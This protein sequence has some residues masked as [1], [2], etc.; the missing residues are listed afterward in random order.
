VLGSCPGRHLRRQAE[1]LRLPAEVPTRPTSSR[2]VQHEI[3][4]ELPTFQWPGPTESSD[5]W[6]GGLI[7]RHGDEASSESNTFLED[8]DVD[9]KT[10]CPASRQGRDD[11]TPR[12]F[13]LVFRDRG[14]DRISLDLP[15]VRLAPMGEARVE[16]HRK[17]RRS[18]AII[19]GGISG[20]RKRRSLPRSRK[21]SSA[22]SSLRCMEVRS[23]PWPRRKTGLYFTPSQARVTC[24]RP[25]AAVPKATTASRKKT[26]LASIT[27]PFGLESPEPIA[28]HPPWERSPGTSIR[29]T[30]TLPPG[31]SS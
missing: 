24:R 16:D 23:E 10:R 5:L 8:L 12:Q 22:T 27:A 19:Q 3:S 6:S 1:G 21:S 17:R 14:D 18:G 28:G 7:G 25:P 13:G 11:R 29:S 15:S 26:K 9:Q 31:P 20:R 4:E 30:R 2:M